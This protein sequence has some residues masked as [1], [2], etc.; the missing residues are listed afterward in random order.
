M[1][2]SSEN[3]KKIVETCF[4]ILAENDKE[5][6]IL[7]RNDLMEFTKFIMTTTITTSFEQNQT[8]LDSLH[9][10]LEK[11]NKINLK[12]IDEICLN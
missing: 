12:N 4:P 8:T 1:D 5:D 11:C 7:S 6:L 9:K 10:E 3:I 2:I